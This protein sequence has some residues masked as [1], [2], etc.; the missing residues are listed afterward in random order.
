MCVLCCSETHWSSLYFE[1]LF[2]PGEIFYMGCLSPGKYWVM[3]WCIS[4]RCWHIW[5]HV[6]QKAPLLTSP[7]I[8]SGMSLP[9]ADSGR[10]TFSKILIFAESSSF[11]SATNAVSCLP[12][13][14]SSHHSFSGRCLS[15]TAAWI[16][17]VCPL[18]VLLGKSG[19][20]SN[21]RLIQL[22]TQTPGRT[23]ALPQGSCSPSL[24]AFHHTE[25]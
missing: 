22:G 20:P 14:A 3:G 1:W 11:S 13:S 19:T 12:S 23:G 6:I 21:R 16:G 4:S 5:L 8:S 2:D 15:T 25:Y 10:H 7:S 9:Q 24:F 18:V 17:V